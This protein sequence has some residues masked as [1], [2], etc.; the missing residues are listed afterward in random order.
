VK[1]QAGARRLGSRLRVNPTGKVERP[2]H[3]RSHHAHESREAIAKEFGVTRFAEVAWHPRY[4]VA[5]SQVVEA[6]ISVD[7]EKRLGPMRWGFVSPT[8]E[9]PKLALDRNSPARAEL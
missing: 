8:V 9:E 5:P 4:N 7:G 3:V 1:V 2:L 6:I